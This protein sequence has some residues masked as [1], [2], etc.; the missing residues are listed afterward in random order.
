[1]KT[2]NETLAKELEAKLDD[3]KR[4]VMATYKTCDAADTFRMI[5]D[6]DRIIA[7]AFDHDPVIE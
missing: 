1:M 2:Y 7:Y 3:W 5:R 6:V 4:K